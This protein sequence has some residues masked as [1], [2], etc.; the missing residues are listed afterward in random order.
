[1]Q[2]L[3][4]KKRKFWTL[5]IFTIVL[6]FQIQ[7]IVLADDIDE[8]RELLQEGYYKPVSQ[9]ILD[10]PTIDEILEKLDP[11][12]TY[13]TKQE[14]EDFLYFIDMNY[15]GIGI[16]GEEHEQGVKVVHLFETGAAIHSGLQLGDII[17]G[18]NGTSLTGKTIEEAQEFLLGSP[19]T[20][21]SLKVLRPN[22]NETLSIPIKRAKTE[23]APTVESAWLGG[24]IGYI[25]LNSFNENSVAEMK[26]AMKS[27]GDV[28]G[29]IIDIRDDGGGYLDAAQDVAGFFPNV[30]IALIVEG[31]DLEKKAFMTNKQNPQ[32]NGPISLLINA[33]SASAS[34][35]LAGAIQDQNGAKLYGQTTYGKGVAQSVFE[36]SSGNFFKM[37]VA[38]FYTPDG[39]VI[40]GV[41]ISPDIETET[42]DELKT[43]H[44]DM[45]LA[46]DDVSIVAGEKYNRAVPRNVEITL[47]LD[48]AL[49]PNDLEERISLFKLSGKNVEVDVVPVALNR[50]TIIPKNQLDSNSSYLLKIDSGKKDYVLSFKTSDKMEKKEEG[51]AIFSDI[52]TGDFFADS[53]NVLYNEGLLKG[54]GEKRFGPFANVTREQ[55]AVFFARI[56]GLDT[57]A[58]VDPGFSDVKPNAY[59]YT[60]VA[61]VKKAG[62]MEGKSKTQF[63]TGHVLTR[64]EMSALLARAFQLQ[65]DGDGKVGSEALEAMPF[66]D[67]TSSPF[68]ADILT[69][70]QSGLA[71]GTT[72]TTFSPEKTVTRGEFATFLYRA[73]VRTKA[74]QNSTG[75][76]SVE[77]AG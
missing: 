47:T 70:Y 19:G 66:V 24:N 41:G 36:L 35:I 30:E 42:G 26:K 27:V 7:T 25:R 46:N 51:Q 56:L 65:A 17:I 20:I 18:V 60:S 58:V 16:I 43:A 57:E 55:A 37:T 34:E 72:K 45:L 77:A 29:W 40:D 74:I 5:F 75:Q 61:A 23:I 12:T 13:F 39:K 6:V 71:G 8:I 62:I 54:I 52:K 32:L 50:F 63:G 48:R 3:F 1:M 76:F 69:I 11:Y 31:R 44:R 67:V 28:G 22:T 33:E 14:F 2:T 64:G 38:Q 21:A 15:V 4:L 68:K 9:E 73:L 10:K 53:A 59:Y 49:T